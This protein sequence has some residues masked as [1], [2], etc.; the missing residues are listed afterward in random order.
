ML[1]VPHSIMG[2]ASGYI[3]ARY[4]YRS[5]FHRALPAVTCRPPAVRPN[6]IH[7]IKHDGYRLWRGAIPSASA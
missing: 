6:W 7:E 1:S 5:A 2:R 4:A 3:A